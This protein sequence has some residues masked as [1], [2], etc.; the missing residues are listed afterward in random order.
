M[1]HQNLQLD[2][3]CFTLLHYCTAPCLSTTLGE[4]FTK[5]KREGRWE[6]Y[7]PVPARNEASELEH[8]I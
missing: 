5:G 6:P 2:G 3:D 1:G 4:T 7:T 8:H